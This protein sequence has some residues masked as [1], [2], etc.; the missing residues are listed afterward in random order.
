MKLLQHAGYLAPG[1]LGPV[2]EAI[3]VLAGAVAEVQLHGGPLVLDA[4]ACEG[5]R[6]HI[7]RLLEGEVRVH[8]P[9]NVTCTAHNKMSWLLQMLGQVWQNIIG[10]KGL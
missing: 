2:A 10:L 5:A 9:L 7:H 8:L 3:A 6:P 1:R 4:Q